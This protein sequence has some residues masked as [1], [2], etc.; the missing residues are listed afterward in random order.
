[1]NF[2][3]A[4]PI[5]QEF[6]VAYDKVILEKYENSKQKL[7]NI[8]ESMLVHVQTGYCHNSLGSQMIIERLGDFQYIDQ[9]LQVCD[10]G[11]LESNTEE[12][13]GDA[14]LMVYLVSKVGTKPKWCR[15]FIGLAEM[16]SVC[17]D[18]IK[19]KHSTN[20]FP[21][22]YGLSNDAWVSADNF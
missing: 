8:L 14:D 17:L 22:K 10:L 7:E 4:K 15:G 20:H 11:K 5:Y 2:C 19:Y 12:N 21:G 13:I 18:E 1:M 6:Q 3:T 9:E 16:G